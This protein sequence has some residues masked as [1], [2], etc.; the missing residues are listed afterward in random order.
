MSLVSVVLNMLALAMH[1]V[2]LEHM[3][4]HINISTARCDAAYTAAD[5]AVYRTSSL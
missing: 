4:A 2:V 1:R 5:T 3:H